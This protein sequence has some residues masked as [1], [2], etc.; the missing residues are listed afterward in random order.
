M[1][2]HMQ[3]QV[4]L[5]TGATSGIGAAFARSFASKNYDLIIT[6]RR[7]DK[8][9]ILAQELQAKYGINIEV[10]IIELTNVHDL[11]RLIQKVKAQKN[12][13]I[14]INNAGFGSKNNFHASD[15]IVWENMLKVHA[16]AVI[17]LT[18][19]A[20][21]NMLAKNFGTIINVSSILAFFPYRRHAM[22]TATKAFINLFTKTIAKELKN[23]G[24]RVQALC[25]GLTVTDFHMQMGMDASKAY[26]AHG[27][28]KPMQPDAVVAKSLKCLKKNK[29]V[30]IPG[31][32]N[33]L[34][35]MLAVLIRFKG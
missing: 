4:A 24:V 10:I 29:T 7:A 11:A 32:L 5:I 15:I 22:Y 25:P 12:L 18:H 17:Q 21:P 28:I 8:I 13:S 34:V 23:T 14:L 1:S 27:F 35:V 6:G 3:R 9:K 30:C 26:K 19:A 33:K 31:F 16:E 20:L 2:I